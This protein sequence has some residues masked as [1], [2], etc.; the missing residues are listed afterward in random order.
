VHNLT[1]YELAEVRETTVRVSGAGVPEV[2]G[3]YT[4]RDVRHNAGFYVLPTVYHGQDVIFTLYKCSLK[5]GGFQWFISITP[6]GKEPGTADDIDFYY[7]LAKAHDILPRTQWYRMNPDPQKYSRD[8]APTT[9]F[10]R[11]DHEPQSVAV[12]PAAGV[13]HSDPA[14]SD[15]DRES[16][17]MVDDE[18]VDDSFAT[19]G[20]ADFYE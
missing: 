8:P 20:S 4:F 5:N 14:S 6:P 12:A 15:S 9:T 1:E 19:N 10:L 7:A 11:P 16:F 3:D 18:R 2:N 13:G 17:M